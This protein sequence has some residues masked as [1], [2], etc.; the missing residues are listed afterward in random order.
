MLACAG[1]AAV[2]A[3]RLL[4]GRGALLPSGR[5]WLWLLLPLAAIA[6]QRVFDA[7]F[8]LHTDLFALS[9]GR[10]LFGQIVHWLPVRALPVAAFFG[11]LL[12]DPAQGRLLVLLLLVAAGARGRHL[13]RGPQLLP[14]LLVVFA[15][16]GYMLVFIGSNVNLG[17]ADGPAR[18]LQYHLAAAADRTVLHVLPTAVL[19]LCMQLA[20]DR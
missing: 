11:G 9:E 13:L 10:G 18:G 19:A 14:L 20:P 4:Q 6:L 5:Q 12:L 3:V 8:G 7:W 16:L 17:G 15:L 1:I 2:A